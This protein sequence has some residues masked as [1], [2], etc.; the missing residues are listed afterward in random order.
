MRENWWIEDIKYNKI[1]QRGHIEQGDKRT[2]K[3]SILGEI[4]I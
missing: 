3:R 4:N 2:K 1:M